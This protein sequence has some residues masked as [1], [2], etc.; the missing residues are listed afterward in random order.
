MTI[1]TQARSRLR[2]LLV[3]AVGT[4]AMFASVLAA[5]AL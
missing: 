1:D 3:V 2:V 4:V 5:N